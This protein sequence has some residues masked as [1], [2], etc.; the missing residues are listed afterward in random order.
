MYIPFSDYA[1]PIIDL[2]RLTEHSN[3]IIPVAALCGILQFS[4]VSLAPIDVAIWMIAFFVLKAWFGPH[5]DSSESVKVIRKTAGGKTTSA[6]KTRSKSS[7]VDEF[8]V[9]SLFKIVTIV[10]Y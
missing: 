1:M 2:N 5:S 3:V 6:R 10:E 4:G 7:T 9:N 8:Y